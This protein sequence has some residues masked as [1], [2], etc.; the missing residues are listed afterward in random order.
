MI[1]DRG[2][3]AS[4]LQRATEAGVKTLMLTVDLP[5]A[6]TRYRDFRSGMSGSTG[7]GNDLRRIWQGLTR[8]DWLLDV[9]FLGGPHIFGNLAGAGKG[10][11]GLGGFAAWVAANFDPSLTWKDMDWLRAHWQGRI[12]VKGVL[13]P[14]DARSALAAGAD[15]LLVSNHGGRQLDGVLATID[16][17]PTIADVAEGRA[18]VFL[19]GGVRS[20]LDV[21]RALALGADGVFLGRAWAYALAAQ[22]ERGVARAL[23]IIRS[24]LL[25]AMALTGCT[26]VRKADTSLLV[27][28]SR[29]VAT[30]RAD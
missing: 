14:E 10:A 23:A 11:L 9:Q 21:L 6:G 2:F 19:D 5:V 27:E 28:A 22:G 12:V 15:G 29:I 17:L 16:A 20:G 26:D 25:T 4:L 13:D 3:M 18:P 30:P 1:K 8:P 24:E 7:L